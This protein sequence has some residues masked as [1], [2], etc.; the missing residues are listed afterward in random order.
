VSED[1]KLAL[2]ALAPTLAVLVNYLLRQN[3]EDRAHGQLGS[4]L[5]DI[6]HEIISDGDELRRLEKEI[7]ELKAVQAARLSKERG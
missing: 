4:R 5:D 1:V 2:V 6:H 7:V 3:A